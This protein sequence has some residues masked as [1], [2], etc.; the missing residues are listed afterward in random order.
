M[1][2][3]NTKLYPKVAIKGHFLKMKISNVKLPIF[4]VQISC[5]LFFAV[6]VTADLFILIAK[7]FN[8]ILTVFLFCCCN[9][10]KKSQLWEK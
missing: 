2:T 5:F 6:E 7:I 4:L 8:I 9:Y 1:W 3:I 10:E